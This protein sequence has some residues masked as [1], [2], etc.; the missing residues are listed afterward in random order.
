M[1][2]LRSFY[3]LLQHPLNT[4]KPLSL[5]FRILL[6]KLFQKNFNSEILLEIATKSKL[7]IPVNSSYGSIIAYCQGHPDPVETQLLM[8]Y[9]QKGDVVVD[10][11]ANIGY[12]SILSASLGASTHCFEPNIKLREYIRRSASLNSISDLITVRS[13]I[14][15][16]TNKGEN[17]SFEFE[18]ELSHISEQTENGEVLPSIRLDDYVQQHKITKIKFLKIDVEGAEPK[19][20]KGMK[21][22]LHNNLADYLLFEHDPVNNHNKEYKELINWFD[23]IHK[24][25]SINDYRLKPFKVSNLDDKHNL[26]VKL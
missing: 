17:F 14:V 7:L 1:N 19:V 11:G 25:F 12:Y 22:L 24:L 3:L 26:F 16:D 13:E 5:I 15:S 2:Y 8:R 23:S 6:W 4:G 20:F 21:T 18:S 10:I 9:V